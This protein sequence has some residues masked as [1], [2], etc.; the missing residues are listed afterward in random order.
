MSN[1]HAIIARGAPA[2]VGAYSMLW[3]RVDCVRVGSGSY[4]PSSGEIVGAGVAE[5]TNQ[6]IDNVEA[7]LTAAGSG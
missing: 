1:P 5:Q 4:H 6:V 7:I 2:P 3:C